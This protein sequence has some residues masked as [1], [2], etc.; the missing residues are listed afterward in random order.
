MLLTF[1][2]IS[3]HSSFLIPVS[4]LLLVWDAT[5]TKEKIIKNHKIMAF[6]MTII[7]FCYFLQSSSIRQRPMGYDR[8]NNILHGFKLVPS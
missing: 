7:C 3:H 4:P 6:P 1:F 5:Q 2:N 8:L